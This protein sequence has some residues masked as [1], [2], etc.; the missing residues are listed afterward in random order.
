MRAIMVNLYDHVA[1]LSS[2][3]NIQTKERDIHFPLSY[4]IFKNPNKRKE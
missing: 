2:P 3:Y 4:L 1:P